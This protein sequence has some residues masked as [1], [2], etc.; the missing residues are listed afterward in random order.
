MDVSS[1]KGPCSVWATAQRNAP[2]QRRGRYTRASTAHPAKMLPAIAAH[3][4]TTYTRPGDWVLDPMCG[5]GTTL[6]EAAHAGRNGL[7]IEYEPRWAQA[8]AENLALAERSGA[9]GHGQILIGDARSLPTVIPPE[10]HGRFALVVTSPPYGASVHGRVRSTRDSGEP[11]VHKFNDAYGTDRANLA[12]QPLARLLDGF[13]DILTGCAAVLRPGGHVVVTTRP[14]RRGG[15]LIDLPGLAAA[16]GQAA[17][18]VFEERCVAL[19]A[20]IRDGE[21]IP[22]PSFF[23]LHNARTAAQAGNPQAV[24]VH[25]DVLILAKVALPGSSREPKGV[26]AKPDG[27]Q[28]RAAVPR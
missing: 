20:A 21:L 3:A 19:L 18:L 17:G 7:G 13:T 12:H 22:R 28:P 8:A 24:I 14:W 25:E 16:C 6:V 15:E 11:G 27:P 26:Q 9:P 10:L 5:T 23:A 2:A 4:I 1:V